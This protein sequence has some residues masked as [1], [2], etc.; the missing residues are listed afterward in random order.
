MGHAE[1]ASTPRQDGL[2]RAQSLIVSS[3]AEL[4]ALGAPADIAA[5]LDL[6]LHRIQRELDK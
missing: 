2:K 1:K 6:A 5:H 4:D 3:V